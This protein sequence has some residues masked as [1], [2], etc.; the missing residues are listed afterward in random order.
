MLW[1]QNTANHLWLFALSSFSA[2]APP[3]TTCCGLKDAAPSPWTPAF[4]CYKVGRL[5][6]SSGLQTQGLG[7]NTGPQVSE[8]FWQE[9]K[10]GAGPHRSHPHVSGRGR[11]G[12]V[13]GFLRSEEPA[14]NVLFVPFPPVKMK[15]AGTTG[16]ARGMAL[17]EEEVS[18]VGSGPSLSPRLPTRGVT[19]RA[20]SPDETRGPPT[21]E[22]SAGSSRTRTALCL[23][24]LGFVCEV[25]LLCVQNAPLPQGHGQA[26][27]AAC[28][29][30]GGP[31]LRVSAGLSRDPS[32][33]PREKIA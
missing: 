23:Q 6:L 22:A 28:L 19:R 16:S 11:R 26:P 8:P 33:R 15:R 31:N 18:R 9:S 2:P 7:G 12:G 1:P 25:L 27:W 17:Y 5:D 21:P 24:V 32:V 4:P 30:N 10:G 13:L 29:A 3:P 20:P 14:D